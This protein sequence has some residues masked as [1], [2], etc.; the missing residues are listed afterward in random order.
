[1][2]S[3]SFFNPKPTI[4]D[5]ELATGLRW[6]TL[7]GTTSLGLFSITTSGFL[8]AFALALGANNFH[9]GV[10]AALPF[11]M[12]IQVLMLTSHSGAR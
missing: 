11:I 10:L 7:E 5:R 1:M 6:F 8:V 9:I 12:Q 2:Q 3:F 4:S